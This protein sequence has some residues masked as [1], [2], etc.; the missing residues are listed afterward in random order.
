[1]SKDNFLKGAA[2]LGIAGFLVKILGAI[3]R[4]PLGNMLGDVGMGYYQTAYPLYTL[5]Y[6]IS[7]A[8]LPVAV[9]KLVS[10]KRA[11]GDYRGAQRIFKV[12]FLG[13]VIGGVLTFTFVFVGAKF[14]VD[15]L[16]NS[17][18]YYAMIALAPALLFTPIMSAFRGYFQGRQDMTPTALSQ[19]IEQFFRVSVGLMV[20]GIIMKLDKGLP[21]AAGGASF[22]ASAG[23]LLGTIIIMYIYS[24]R[25]KK[26]GR[27]IRKSSRFKRE[28]TK[29]II[30]NILAISIPI[31][32][33]ACIIPLFG[34]IDVAIVMKR[35]QS[36]GYTEAEASGLYGQ[37]TGMAQTL[38]NFPQVFSVAIAASLVPA[39]STAF[40]KKD[41]REIK[42][43]ATSGIRVTLLVG[44]PAALG[45]FILSTP[46]IKLL[47]F[48]NPLEVQESAGQILAVLSFSVI[49]L[50]LVQSLTAILQG[51]GKPFIPVRNLLIGVLVKV[52]VVY[53]LT[54]IPQINIKGAA[55]ST[56]IAYTIAAILNFAS[57][58]HYTN[59]KFNILNLVIK[60][61]ISVAIMGIVVWVT[62]NGANT[63]IG[64]KLATVI[65]I[66]LGGIIYGLALLRTGTI[67]SRDF[68]LIPGGVKLAIK[69]KKIGLLK[70]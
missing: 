57:V 41:Y 13:L 30:R 50:T 65:S 39:I 36:I 64:N 37:L 26:I 56:I 12:A 68:D 54:G 22:G 24:K 9:A 49:F 25:K 59:I 2:I 48:G 69:L 45:L 19:I 67:T 53:V 38:I 16:G 27:E 20:V 35:L 62:Y 40:A 52:V 18:A 34:T 31:T 5:M 33:G 29:S 43:T 11:M 17:N 10:E 8:G 44:L 14:I 21:M 70:K 66:S 46:I 6:A 42:K 4:I 51:I 47:Y 32:I 15:K 23:A 1:M 61:M 28:S 63:M 7:T 60:P 55:L 58:K 3:Y